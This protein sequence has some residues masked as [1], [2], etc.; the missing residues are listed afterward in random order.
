MLPSWRTC[1]RL[2]GG[3]SVASAPTASDGLSPRVSPTATAARAFRTLCSPTSGR[4]R[5]LAAAR[6][7]D[8]KLR[9]LPRRASACSRR[10]HR[11]RLA[12]RTVT[13]LPLKSRPN[14]ETYSSSALSTAAP[15]AGSDSINSYLARAIPASESKN[16]RCTGATLVT[17]PIS[18]CAILRQRTNLAGMGHS[19]FNHSDIVLRLQLQAA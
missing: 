1:P 5:M 7:D 15:L 13:T 16:S 2:S 14:W 9:A 10:A 19:H 4:R 18:G 6:D 11:R 3:A 12:C 8:V 17:T